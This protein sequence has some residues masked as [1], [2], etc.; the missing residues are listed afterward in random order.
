MHN[1]KEDEQ[2]KNTKKLPKE[3]NKK[4]SMKTVTIPRKCIKKIMMLILVQL[5][6]KMTQEKFTWQ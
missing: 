4:T 2:N 3:E 5:L 1:E 6:I